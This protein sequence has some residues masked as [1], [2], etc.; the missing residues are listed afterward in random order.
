MLIRCAI[1][2]RRKARRV[3]EGFRDE[4]YK[5]WLKQHGVCAVA[6]IAG[7]QECRNPMVVDPAHTAKVNGMS[8]KGPDSSCAPLCRKHHDLYD[9]GRE[10]FE[11]KYG[12]NMAA[13]AKRWHERYLRETKECSLKS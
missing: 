8:S 6:P 13:I 12:L 2:R 5:R 1:K 9:A 3:P 10:A 11:K 4:V 7:M